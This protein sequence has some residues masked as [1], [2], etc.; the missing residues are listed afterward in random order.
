FDVTGVAAD[1]VLNIRERPSA[2]A[3]IIGRLAPTAT[4]VEVVTER[5]G[6]MQVNTR[7]RSGWV[8]GRYL[9]YRTDVWE[10][11]RL[12]R[13]LSCLGTEPFWALTLGRG[14]DMVLSRPDTGD[15]RY[16][17]QK[18]LGSGWFRDPRR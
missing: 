18:V 3:P 1:D 15:R 10:E 2:S 5:N 8:N 17:V 12:P 11:G 9:M 14:A 16:A 7:E 6:W 13:T 4:N